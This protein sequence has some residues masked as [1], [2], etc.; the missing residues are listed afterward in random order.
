M[1]C[2]LNVLALSAK[3]A[4]NE[5]KNMLFVKLVSIASLFACFVQSIPCSF[6]TTGINSKRRKMSEFNLFV[7]IKARVGGGGGGGFLTGTSTSKSSGR[8][9]L[10]SFLSKKSL[11]L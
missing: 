11:C 9:C 2:R 4:F 8:D 1:A 5:P 10:K 3:Y 6:P 7:T